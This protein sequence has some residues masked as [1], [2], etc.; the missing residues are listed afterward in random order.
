MDEAGGIRAAAKRRSRQRIVRAAA[1]R[2]RRDGV[3]G[4]G[5]ADVMADAGLTHGAFYS[6]FPDKGALVAA[7]LAD[8]IRRHEHWMDDPA[9]DAADGEGSLSDDR[10][11]HRA[12]AHILA[13]RYLNRGHRDKPDA[14]CP[15]PP[16]LVELATDPAM[17]AELRRSLDRLAAR[18]A[19]P[20]PGPDSAPDAAGSARRGA[21]ALTA[22]E[23]AAGLFAACIGGLLMARALDGTESDCLLRDV[24]RF[25]DAAFA[26]E[27]NT[28]PEE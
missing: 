10:L 28:Q 26:G 23:R 2:L 7:A 8:A 22:N 20:D 3:A 25:I 19:D 4:T 14:G 5:V 21:G 6:H 24:R 9:R 16:L 27:P 18:F 12:R 1:D 13:R 17:G 15:Y 11:G